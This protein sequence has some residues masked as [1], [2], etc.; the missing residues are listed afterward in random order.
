ML[1]YLSKYQPIY[2]SGPRLPQ[3]IIL[4]ISVIVPNTLRRGLDYF[5][6]CSTMSD[7]MLS[8]KVCHGDVLELGSMWPHESEPHGFWITLEV[9]LAKVF[10]AAL[11]LLV[12]G[13][14]AQDDAC[15]CI[16][17]C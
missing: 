10:M 6:M 13:K 7:A 12:L 5:L 8:C 1:S 17:P 11:N 3:L 2:R 4:C 9:E 14:G 16:R 15:S